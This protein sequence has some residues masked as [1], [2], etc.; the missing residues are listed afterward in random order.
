[1]WALTCFDLSGGS[2][3]CQGACLCF[4]CLGAFLEL[5]HIGQNHLK[6]NI[7]AVQ[8][9]VATN[10]LTKSLWRKRLYKGDAW[11]NKDFDALY[12]ILQKQEGPVE[13]KRAQWQSGM[14]P[15]F[16]L[17]TG[18]GERPRSECSEDTLVDPVLSCL[19]VFQASCKQDCKAKENYKHSGQA[20]KKFPIMKLQ[21]LGE[22]ISSF[23]SRH[24][25]NLLN[26]Q[27]ISR[28]RE[29]RFRHAKEYSLYKKS[30]EKSLKQLQPII[31]SNNKG[32]ICF[33]ELPH[34][35]IINVQYP[36]G[37]CACMKTVKYGI[38]KNK[39][40]SILEEAQTYYSET[41]NPPS[42]VQ[43]KSQKKHGELCM[44]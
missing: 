6:V 20:L 43:S 13:L 37:S 2:V 14:Y 10:T 22:Y 1:M 12:Y 29:Q 3:R 35:N 8:Q 40:G 16:K 27:L 31:S 44:N 24:L 28:L 21:R 26:H 41:L 18:V 33:P 7:L 9:P 4:A 34:G 11:E 17:T 39:K 32:E 15:G 23:G 30:L 25:G 5:R 19:A 38:Q 42:L 36:T